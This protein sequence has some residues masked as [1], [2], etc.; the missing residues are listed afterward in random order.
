[1]RSACETNIKV[2]SIQD[3]ITPFFQPPSSIPFPL[4]LNIALILILILLTLTLWLTLWL[5]PWLTPTL[6]P[7]L[8]PNPPHPTTL[9]SHQS[10]SRSMTRSPPIF[11]PLILSIR[12][13]SRTTPPKYFIIRLALTTHM[14]TMGGMVL[15][16]LQGGSEDIG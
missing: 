1:M 14:N 4:I 11:R 13:P 7:T 8:N 9:L 2:F 10:Q 15:I 6:K 5:T 3:L 12:I 16:P